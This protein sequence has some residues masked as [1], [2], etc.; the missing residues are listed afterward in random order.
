M[1]TLVIEVRSVRTHRKINKLH[2]FSGLLIATFVGLHLIN[3][4][5]SIFGVEEHIELMNTMRLFYRNI[6]IE[7]ILL[8][9][10]LI[11]II[12]GLHLFRTNRK[13]AKLFFDKLQ[14][15]SGFYLAIFLMI[16][17]GAVLGGRIIL[18][19]DTNFYFGVAGINTFPFNLF[20][21]P[22]Y[23]LAIISFFG[24]VAAIHN[25]KMKSNIMGMSPIVQSIGILLLGFCITLF[26]FYGLT[27]RFQGVQ[28][29]AEYNILIGK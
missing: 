8:V 25:K 23:S 27:Y 18:D 5:W 15:W 14:L 10:V 28:I 11:Q 22:Y 26:I 13:K 6:I 29:P 19:L 4:G 21:V 16:H 3:H 7:S 12:S 17:L 9:A 2:Y 20:F 24:H 1:K